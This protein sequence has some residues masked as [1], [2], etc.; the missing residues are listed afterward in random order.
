MNK[1]DYKILLNGSLKKAYKKKTADVLGYLVYKHNG[2]ANYRQDNDGFF[3]VGDNDFKNDLGISIPTLR[4]HISKLIMDGLVLKKSGRKGMKNQYKLI[5]E[6][7]STNFQYSFTDNQQDKKKTFSSIEGSEKNENFQLDIERDI[8]RDIDYID[9]IST[10]NI[11]IE[12]KTNLNNNNIDL[13]YRSLI[14]ENKQMVEQIQELKEQIVKYASLTDELIEKV[15]KLEDAV[16]ALQDNGNKQTDEIT[17]IKQSKSNIN[18]FWDSWNRFKDALYHGDVENKEQH[19]QTYI[20]KVKALYKD[21][22][23][24]LQQMEEQY[25]KAT[26]KKSNQSNSNFVVKDDLKVYMDLRNNTSI[27]NALTQWLQQVNQ[28]LTENPTEHR[29]QAKTYYINY[30]FKVLPDRPKDALIKH[31]NKNIPNFQIN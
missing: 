31:W 4:V 19:Y 26:S 9:N 13:F 3:G 6:T 17:D 22:T 20:N 7:F 11:S 16:I 27:T 30:M 1:I 28:K 23:K 29:E 25:N 18:S 12:N 2:Y 8:E 5:Y 14:K 24:A 10:D 21:P 15:N